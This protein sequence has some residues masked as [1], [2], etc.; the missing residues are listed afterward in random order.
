MHTIDKR[1]IFSIAGIYGFRMLGLFVILPIFSLYADKIID[2]TPLLIGLALGIYGLTQALL[3][4]VF[5]ILSDRYGRK[6]IIVFGLLLFIFGS[7][8]CAL[9]S[10][11]YG[12]I[13]GRALQGAGAIGSTLTA[14]VA[15][16]TQE[17]SRMKAMSVIGMTIGFSFLIAMILGP[18]LNNMVGL[19]GIFW[20]TA[21]LG[22]CGIWLVIFQVPTPKRIKTHLQKEMLLSR[23]L[24]VLKNRELLRLNFGILILHASLTAL[25]ITVPI[26]LRNYLGISEAHQWLVYLPT[27]VVAFFLMVPFI[28]IAESKNRMK[29][30]FVCA[31]GVLVLMPFLLALTDHHIVLMSL[32]L[33]L[34]FAS[35]TLLEA[36]LPSLVSKICPVH[37]KG[38]AMGIFSSFQFFG[39]FVGGSLGGIVFHHYGIKGIF[40]FNGIMAL[41]W[42]AIAVTMKQ[43]KPLSSKIFSMTPYR[44]KRNATDLEQEILNVEGVEEVLVCMHEYVAYLKVDKRYFKEANFSALFSR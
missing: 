18:I 6:P 8:I 33:M 25:F 1:V 10:T 13:I 24:R 32:F 22:G 20:L 9:S 37:S 28:I 29:K 19:S 27:L 39:F 43:P 35:F 17:E 38:T 11:I 42:F 44:G 14:L 26:I 30:V 5:G 15:D 40:L 23:I 41:I 16:V 3:Q 34:F 12:M 4:I 21:V 7:I 36:A 31:V 2:A